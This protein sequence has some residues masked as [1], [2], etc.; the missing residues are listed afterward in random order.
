MRAADLRWQR[1]SRAAAA[2]RIVVAGPASGF[3]AGETSAIVR[4][5]SAE[6]AR[7]NA[8]GGINGD[9]VSVDVMDDGCDA[10]VAARLADALAAQKPDL[11]LGHPCASAALAASAVYGKTGVLFIATATRHPR[12]TDERA[13]PT[14]FRVGGRDDEQGEAAGAY[15]ASLLKSGFAPDAGEAK[16]VTAAIVHDGTRASQDIAQRTAK[17]VIDAGGAKPLIQA[18]PS[19]Q[20]D[21][22]KTAAALKA[23]SVVFFAGYPMEAGLVLMALRQAGSQAR[24]IV[25]DSVRTAGFTGTFGTSVL[26]VEAL[27]A[28]GGSETEPRGEI[29]ASA[30]VAV[31]AQAARRAH[32][33]DAAMV[34]RVIQQAEFETKLGKVV[35]EPKGDARLERPD[36]R[37]AAPSGSTHLSYRVTSWDGTAWESISAEGR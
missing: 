17:A 33:V 8:S 23:A 36:A 32:G 13:G 15:L 20:K 10:A 27:A 18:I 28:T 30:A 16:A 22:A 25:S 37:D 7:L 1:P 34:A 6:A 2:V 21:Y 35:F 9:P 19:G 31:F 12:L 4:A 5:A 14:I 3:G 26:G 29:L 24:F 11:V